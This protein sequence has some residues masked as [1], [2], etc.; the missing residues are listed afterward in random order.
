MKFPRCYVSTQKVSD[1]TLHT[2][3]IR[4]EETK[5]VL[6]KK[7]ALHWLA[8]I[9]PGGARK[10]LGEKSYRQSYPAVDSVN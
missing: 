3:A 5:P 8:L 6:T 4:Q 9:L 2:F 1:K 10:A 7:H